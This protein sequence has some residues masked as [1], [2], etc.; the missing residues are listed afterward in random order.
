MEP[1]RTAPW[2]AIFDWDGVVIDS[3]KAH[4]ESWDRLAREGSR[5]LPEGHFVKGFGRKNDFIIPE[6]LGWTRDAAE[7]QQLSLR[8]EEL[9]RLVVKERGQVALPGVRT[10]LERLQ[11]AGVPCAIGSSTHRANIELILELVGLREFFQ[12]IVTAE[13]VK[14]GKPNPEVFLKAAGKIDRPPA[15]CVA[16]EDAHV[17]IAAAK[18]GG[19]R[20]VGVA[21]THPVEEL[22][23]ADLAV[24]RL[25]EL[26]VDVLGKLVAG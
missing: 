16:F 5:I 11:A 20:V 3:S 24:R 19:M 2:G 12:A 4:E 6:I 1:A 14:E 9:Y 7:I 17:G 21:T 22:K 15:R 25:D 26:E 18:A 10:W 13:D 8:K 23:E